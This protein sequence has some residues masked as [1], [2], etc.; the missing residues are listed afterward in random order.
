MVTRHQPALLVHTRTPVRWIEKH[1]CLRDDHCHVSAPPSTISWV[2]PKG[3]VT[4]ALVVT[5]VPV[6]SYRAYTNIALSSDQ[7]D[8]SSLVHPSQLSA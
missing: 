7:D 1:R 8:P 6:H 5:D 2:G 4:G 3:S